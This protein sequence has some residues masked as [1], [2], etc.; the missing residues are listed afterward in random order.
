MNITK[1]VETLP[2]QYLDWG[3]PSVRPIDDLV[4]VNTQVWSM[5]VPNNMRLLNHA[6]RFLEDD[7]V[8]LEVGVLQGASTIA[9]LLNNAARGVAVDNFSMLDSAEGNR[10]AFERTTVACGVADRITLYELD[11]VEFFQNPPDIKVGVYFC[12]GPHGYEGTWDGLELAIPI[13]AD[14]AVIIM[15]DFNWSLVYKATDDWLK[16][17]PENAKM[18]FDLRHPE[19]EKRFWNGY[20]VIGWTRGRS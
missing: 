14:R 6:V 5:T 1:F 12:D 10:K 4:S 2:L 3:T 7:E 20:G 19:N 11:F 8:Y 9:A 15:D 16:K 13:L 17:H 18:L